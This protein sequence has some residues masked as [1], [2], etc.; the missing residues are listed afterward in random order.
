MTC[1]IRSLSH[2]CI[3]GISSEHYVIPDSEH[4]TS[5]PQAHIAV[6]KT[7]IPSSMR[8][9]LCMPRQTAGMACGGWGWPDSHFVISSHGLMVS[10]DAKKA[11]E[12]A[13]FMAA[14]CCLMPSSSP[15]TRALHRPVYTKS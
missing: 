2:F 13:A 3:E 4:C 9:S 6:G 12:S 5:S 7:A 15:K 8:L 14:A 10:M 1:M 11:Y